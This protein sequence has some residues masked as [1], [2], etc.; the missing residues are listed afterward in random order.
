MLQTLP[1]FFSAYWVYLVGIAAL[2]AVLGYFSEKI[3]EYL[4]KGLIVF[5]LIFAVIA[6]YE[7]VTG[8]SIISLPGRVDRELSKQPEKVE[9][10]RR[11]YQS[12]EERFGEPPP[13]DK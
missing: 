7:L 10:G 3:R 5:G 9:K 11:Y 12:Y 6:G 2:F 1:D 4:K 13:A 8:N